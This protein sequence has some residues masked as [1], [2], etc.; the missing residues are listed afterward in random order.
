MMKVYKKAG[1]RIYL[2]R[3]MRGYTREVL[4]ESANITAKFLYEIENGRKGFSAGVLYNI[5]QALKV[6]CDYIMTGNEKVG[7]DKALNDALQ[8][9]SEQQTE[10][11]AAILKEIYK[12]I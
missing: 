12:L 8:L 7:Y 9:Y 2:T 5:C 3:I 4:A 6:D 10:T 1:E 11:I